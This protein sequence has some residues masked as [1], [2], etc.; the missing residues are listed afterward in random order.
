[1]Q[2]AADAQA[3]TYM[4]ATSWLHAQ[5]WQAAC[6]DGQHAEMYSA[7]DNQRTWPGLPDMVAAFLRLWGDRASSRSQ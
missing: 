4:K 7:K 1:M 2:Q 5:H 6:R 3:E